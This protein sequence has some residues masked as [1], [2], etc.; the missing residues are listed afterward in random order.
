MAIAAVARWL[1]NENYVACATRSSL[2]DPYPG[3][4]GR[5]EYSWKHRGQWLSIG[6]RFD[7]DAVL[8]AANSQ[9]EFITEH[10]WGYTTQR[11]GGTVEY[12]VEHP[13]WKVWSA[14]GSHVE[15]DVRSFYGPEFAEVLSARPSSAFVAD[16]SPV[17][18]R[19]GC[20]I[21]DTDVTD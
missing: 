14:S 4:N 9:E 13:Q 21:E 11:D 3:I 12:R 20:R 10:Y 17:I 8:P 5:A 1:Y 2:V 19:S 16:G 18:V 7:G 6:A 15:G